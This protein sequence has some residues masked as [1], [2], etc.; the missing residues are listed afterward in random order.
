MENASA[1]DAHITDEK[2][3]KES[4]KIQGVVHDRMDR[5]GQTRKLVSPAAGGREREAK[6]VE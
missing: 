3:H 1:D 4:R 6:G 5:V 2:I